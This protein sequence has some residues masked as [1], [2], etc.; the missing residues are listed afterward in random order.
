MH[1]SIIHIQIQSVYAKSELLDCHSV[2]FRELQ[3]KLLTLYHILKL[4]GKTDNENSKTVGKCYWL[5]NILPALKLRV[6]WMKLWTNKQLYYITTLFSIMNIH[7][8]PTS[9]DLTHIIFGI[10]SKNIHFQYY[11]NVI[12]NLCQENHP[13]IACS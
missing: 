1:D 8:L 13:Y 9:Y 12:T 6:C 2:K 11:I 4:K 10:K 7:C 3:Y 5:K